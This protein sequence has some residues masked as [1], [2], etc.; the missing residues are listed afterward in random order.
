MIV[1]NAA[2]SVSMTACGVP[3]GTMIPNHDDTSAS[4]TPSS[5]SVGV[6]GSERCRVDAVTA[7]GRNL[8]PVMFGSAV[9]TLSNM[10]STSP[11][12]SAT[13]QSPQPLKG[14]C[15][16]VVAVR[17]WNSSPERCSVVPTPFEPMLRLPGFAFA[18]AIS[19]A[20]LAALTCGPTTRMFGTLAKMATGT[21]SFLAL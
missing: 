18:S 11:R 21:R 13:T 3:A 5:A 4:L 1:F 8:P 15:V 6:F 10:M 7:S 2:L 14:M 9:E 20:T 16:S 12:I 17:S 19:S